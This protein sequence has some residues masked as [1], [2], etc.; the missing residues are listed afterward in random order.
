MNSVLHVTRQALDQLSLPGLNALSQSPTSLG[1]LLGGTRFR[2]GM[3]VCMA[4]LCAEWL[5]RCRSTDLGM[6]TFLPPFPCVPAHG[7]CWGRLALLETQFGAPPPP[8]QMEPPVKEE[9]PAPEPPLLLGES[10]AS[11]SAHK[12]KQQLKEW[13]LLIMGRLLCQRKEGDFSRMAI[14]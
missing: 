5:V 14:V 7:S 3:S 8:A 4:S 13:V 10:V 12:Q 1:N 6:R 2:E 11:S 9:V